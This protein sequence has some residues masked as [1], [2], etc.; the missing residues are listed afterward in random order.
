MYM[1]ESLKN[2]FNLQDLP[3]LGA[4]NHTARAALPGFACITVAV[5]ALALR[6]IR[7]ILKQVPGVS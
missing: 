7:V 2:F 4:G 1:D 6:I 3:Y 5:T